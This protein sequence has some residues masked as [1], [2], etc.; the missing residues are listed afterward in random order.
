MPNAP[1]GTKCDYGGS[2]DQRRKGCTLP[3]NKAQR[4][5]SP[6]S[7]LDAVHDKARASLDETAAAAVRSEFDDGRL[8][9]L[10]SGFIC[11]AC[12]TLAGGGSVLLQ[13]SPDAEGVHAFE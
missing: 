1:K 10:G 9:K 4:A 8:R 13:P 3:A 5:F 12:K 2:G 11:N 7:V 6:V